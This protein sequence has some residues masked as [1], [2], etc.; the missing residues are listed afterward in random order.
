[1]G[2]HRQVIAFKVKDCCNMEFASIRQ[3]KEK[4]CSIIKLSDCCKPK[5]RGNTMKRLHIE[6]ELL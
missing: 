3:D 4:C 2:S 1:M 6:K 5:E